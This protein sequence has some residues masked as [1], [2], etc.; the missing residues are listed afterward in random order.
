MIGP[1]VEHDHRVASELQDVTA[2]VEDVLDQAT[3]D[4][5]E[6]VVDVFRTGPPESGQPLGE[7]GEP[8]DV[9]EGERALHFEPSTRGCLI[10]PPR[11]QLRDVG[12]ERLSTPFGHE[13]S[14]LIPTAAPTRVAPITK[15]SMDHWRL[16]CFFHAMLLAAVIC[17]VSIGRM[18]SS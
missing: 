10:E 11:R 12:V 18:S 2:E 1:G 4:D 5:V 16:R 13:P 9:E 15:P 3:E 14:R 8:G 7:G 6:D 17:R